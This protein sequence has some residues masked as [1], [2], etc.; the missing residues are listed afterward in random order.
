LKFNYLSYG[1]YI[2]G[3]F[4]Y[5]KF[6]TESLLSFLTSLG[7]KIQ[8]KQI[9][10]HKFYDNWFAHLELLFVGLIESNANLNLLVSRFAIP[11]LFKSLFTKNK[12]ILVF[13]YEDKRD[14]SSFVFKLYFKLFFV[15]LNLFK[16]KN[17]AILT[18]APFWENYFKKKVKGVT[19]IYFPNLFNLNECRAIKVNKKE[20]LIHLGQ[21]SW[22]NDSMIFELAEKLFKNGYSC[23]FT[24]NDYNE[25]GSFD[26]YEIIAENRESYLNRLATSA[27]TIAFTSINEGWNRLV[28]ESILLGTNVIGLNKGGLGDLLIESN[29]FIVENS[30]QAFEII[31]SKKNT[32]PPE[33]F[34]NK[35]ADVNANQFLRSSIEFIRS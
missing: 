28:H 7:Y 3:G 30:N 4:L 34:I 15:L 20:K 24:T 10:K 1:K 17:L 21:W 6:Y 13:H 32:S 29:S 16:P 33:S 26:S 19:I 22:K 8:F 25:A 14:K 18:V 35:Y 12:Y 31:L 23:Y 9:R 11:A 27:Y 2:T 5:E